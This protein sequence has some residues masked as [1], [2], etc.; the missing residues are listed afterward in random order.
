[1]MALLF[2]L[3]QSQIYSGRFVAGEVVL[4]VGPQHLHFF[5]CCIDIQ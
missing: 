3:R 2:G 1:M 5:V 4:E